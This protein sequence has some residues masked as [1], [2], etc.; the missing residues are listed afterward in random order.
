MNKITNKKLLQY[1]DIE[2][3]ADV[4]IDEVRAMAKELLDARA[5]I[6]NYMA[7]IGENNLNDLGINNV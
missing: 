1:L 4:D 3:R 6:E 7:I 5:M 2:Y